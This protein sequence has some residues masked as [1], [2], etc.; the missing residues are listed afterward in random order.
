M[1]TKPPLTIKGL[2]QWCKDFTS[3]LHGTLKDG[4]LQY[5]VVQKKSELANMTHLKYLR[6][7]VHVEEE[8]AA[9]VSVRDK[10]LDKVTWQKIT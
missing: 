5:P 10:D 8:N 6:R 3:E 9:Y 2:L 4:G 7:L 1:K